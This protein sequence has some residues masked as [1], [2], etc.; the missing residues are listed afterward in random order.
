VSVDSS[1]FSCR[2]PPASRPITSSKILIIHSHQ[3][4]AS[5]MEDIAHGILVYFCFP[6]IIFLTAHF[7]DH[8]L[9]VPHKWKLPLFI[10]GKQAG[11]IPMLIIL[12]IKAFS[13]QYIE[14]FA[15]FA[16]TL[17]SWSNTG[18]LVI[19]HM[20]KIWCQSLPNIA[21]WICVLWKKCSD[22]HSYT[23]STPTLTSCHGTSCINK[24][25]SIDHNLLF[26]EFTHS[27]R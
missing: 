6:E 27:V 4:S 16:F 9:N 10:H 20:S 5:E 22:N 1:E 19:K 11:H 3:S 15:V 17:S 25:F 18:S 2:Y 13:E 26:W 7:I 14:L 12:S 24:E 21:V 23:H 8:T